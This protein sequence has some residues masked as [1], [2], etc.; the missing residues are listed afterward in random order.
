MAALVNESREAREGMRAFFALEQGIV[1]STGA[2]S[3]GGRSFGRQAL[4]GISSPTL[5][6][7]S[8]GR[9]YTMTFWSG[10]SS[11]RIAVNGRPAAIAF[12]TVAVV[13]AVAPAWIVE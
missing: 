8:L 5:G 10:V 9:Q 13:T 1:M 4:V 3:Q 6:A 12:A 11:D 2:L 7:I